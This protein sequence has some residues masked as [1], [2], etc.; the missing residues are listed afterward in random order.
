MHPDIK[1]RERNEP[2]PEPFDGYEK[3]ARHEYGGAKLRNADIG[4]REILTDLG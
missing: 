3:K 1:G 4:A 2:V